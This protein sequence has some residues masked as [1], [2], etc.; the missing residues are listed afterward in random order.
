MKKIYALCFCAFSLAS[1]SHAQIISTI[2]GSSL[3]GAFG[4]DGGLAT[5][6]LLNMP[7]F[8]AIDNSGNLFISD[9]ANYRIRK[10][11]VDGTITT[12]AGTGASIHSGDGGPASAAGLS[13]P[14]GIAADNSGNIFFADASCIREIDAAG[15]ISTIAGRPDTAAYTGD[16]GPASV[17]LLGSPMGIAIDASG[18]IYFSEPNYSVIRKVTAAGI[19]TTIA[20]T[21]AQVHTYGDGVAT[22]T[23]LFRPTDVAVDAAGNVYLSDQYNLEIRKVDP[24]GIMHTAAG[25]SGLAFTPGPATASGI[26]FPNSVAVDSRGN[27]YI[28]GAEANIYMIDAAGNISNICGN[29][30]NGFSGDGGPAA[31][32]QINTYTMVRTDTANNLI[33]ADP[34]NNRVRRITGLPATGS[35]GTTTTVKNG[36]AVTI[37]PNPSSGAFAIQ[38]PACPLPSTITITDLPGRTLQTQQIAPNRTEI[39][40]DISGMPTG[41]YIVKVRN[42]YIDETR[43]V[44][45]R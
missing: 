32:A 25:G 23:G 15:V 34:F 42:N 44:I 17:A 36:D 6:A 18:N 21:G 12:I 9:A 20:G 33:I 22:A 13:S 24:A 4:G 30:T 7:E 31:N 45:I 41:A 27:I 37:Y 39:P 10:V 14:M 11:T 8:V 43:Q 3:T 29:G 19:I 16:G 38:I 1:L 26:S 35:L 2:A 28:G 5:A 40:I